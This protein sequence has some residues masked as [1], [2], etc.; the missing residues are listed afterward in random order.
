MSR[1]WKIDATLVFPARMQG[2]IPGENPNELPKKLGRLHDRQRAT[3]N[4]R[5]TFSSHMVAPHFH[6]MATNLNRRP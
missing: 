4:G 1:R 3:I 5:V 2:V 6:R